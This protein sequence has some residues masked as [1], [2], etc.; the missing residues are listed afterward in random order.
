MSIYATRKLDQNLKAQV[1]AL[2]NNLFV[3]DTLDGLVK[4]IK[5]H[6]YEFAASSYQGFDS[7]TKEQMI[8]YINHTQWLDKS[9]ELSTKLKEI[10][11]EKPEDLWINLGNHY[12]DVDKP[13]KSLYYY[14]KVLQKSKDPKVMANIATL[15]VKIGESDAGLALLE[16]TYSISPDE[17]L[18]LQLLRLK[19]A[20]GR[21][22][23]EE[24][25]DFATGLRPSGQKVLSFLT[26]YYGLKQDWDKCVTCY[27]QLDA[28]HHKLQYLSLYMN[29]MLESDQIKAMESQLASIKEENH[30]AY[31]LCLI[32]VYL[33][34][35]DD[36]KALAL[37]YELAN[38]YDYM[39][40]NIYMSIAYA[41]MN[42]VINSV[43][44]LN[45]VN[46]EALDFSYGLLYLSHAKTLT[47]Y[48]SDLSRE[49]YYNKLLISA[50]KKRYRPMYLQLM[51]TKNW[52]V[53]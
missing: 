6:V 53:L 7:F 50:W 36:E 24:L 8:N 14:D 18:Y 35:Q 11:E 20:L 51:A 32:Q 28:M 5:E 33:D 44:A 38:N 12:F 22:A 45:E 25:D 48:S 10:W 21:I 9:L 16:K 43:S 46:Y 39:E 29:Y 27:L 2:D 30:K 42:Q 23:L 15:L 1:L 34:R 3:V 19:Y 13:D 4:M 31:S 52:K 37:C 49:H 47:S 40:V 41:R 17:G 26:W